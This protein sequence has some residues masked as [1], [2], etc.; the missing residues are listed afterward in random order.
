MTGGL[1]V[2]LILFGMVAAFLVLRLRGGCLK[3]MK[4]NHVLLVH[5]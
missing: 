3:I 1:P 4:L 5:N 2:D